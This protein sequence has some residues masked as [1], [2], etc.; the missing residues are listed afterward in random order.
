MKY[1]NKTK[2]ERDAIY[3]NLKT[4][5]EKVQFMLQV[6]EETLKALDEGLLGDLDGNPPPPSYREL[7]VNNIKYLKIVKISLYKN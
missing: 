7:I 1:I 3:K 4:V 2:E 5:P 6:D